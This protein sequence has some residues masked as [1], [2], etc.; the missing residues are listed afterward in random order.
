M[1]KP[2]PL[3]NHAPSL[4]RTSEGTKCGTLGTG[5]VG[6]WNDGTSKESLKFFSG[7]GTAASTIG[8]ID[9]TWTLSQ[10]AGISAPWTWPVAA[11]K[12]P[13]DAQGKSTFATHS[14][15]WKLKVLFFGL[16]SAI[17]TFQRLM[18][19]GLYRLYW[20]TLLLYRDDVIVI[21]PDFDSHLQSIEKVL[22]QLQD[23]GLKLKPTKWEFL[24]DEVRYLGYVVSAKDVATDLTTVEAITKWEPLENVKASLETA[25]Y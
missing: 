24:H 21:L 2:V 8:S 16:T 9:K 17:A 19:Q 1:K 13:S 25:G 12:F 22:R 6:Q 11:G 7:S 10:A 15:F 18:E 14:G 5:P 20:K 3:E 4:A 23:A